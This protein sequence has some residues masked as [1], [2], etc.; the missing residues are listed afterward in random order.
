MAGGLRAFP[1]V[2]PTAADG[3]CLPNSRCLA[4]HFCTA[5]RFLF[6]SLFRSPS[7]S[8]LAPLAPPFKLHA[9]Y[10]AT[11][12]RRPAPSF[13]TWKPWWRPG[14][15]RH[16][17]SGAV[18]PVPP[19]PRPCPST[20]RPPPAPPQSQPPRQRSPRAGLRLPG[21]GAAAAGGRAPCL[22]HCSCARTSCCSNLGNGSH[23]STQ[24]CRWCR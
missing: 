17:S 9:V 8:G 6:A 23:S 20:G 24:Y 22:L 19:R 18:P 1:W 11:P 14:K 12:I 3:C 2:R 21:R 10:C 16:K 7:T 15:P 5:P 13:Q 4:S